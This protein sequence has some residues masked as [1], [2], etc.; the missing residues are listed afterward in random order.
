[1][2][3]SALL[4][5]VVLMRARNASLSARNKAARVLCSAKTL[6]SEPK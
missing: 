1:M 2:L 3:C 5:R 4:Q 6:M